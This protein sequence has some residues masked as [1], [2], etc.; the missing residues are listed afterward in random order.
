MGWTGERPT[1]VVNFF[2]FLGRTRHHRMWR[3]LADTRLGLFFALRQ[4]RMRSIK[5]DG[6]LFLGSWRHEIYT[7]LRH[8]LTRS[9]CYHRLS[10]ILELRGS[11][12]L[13]LA[14]NGGICPQFEALFVYFLV[15]LQ[16]WV[17]LSL[18]V[19]R[20]NWC[21]LNQVILALYKDRRIRFRILIITE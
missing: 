11:L 13:T 1:C 4:S 3:C 15:D 21:I 8:K 17:L 6:G 18:Y 12:T 14:R 10:K 16:Q 20:S 7:H 2:G 9:R 19:T 5:V